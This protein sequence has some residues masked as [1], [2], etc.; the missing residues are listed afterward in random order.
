MDRP[1][2][3]MQRGATAVSM[4]LILLFLIS[5]LGLIEVSYLYWH[6]RDTQKVA[7]LAALAGAQQLNACATDNSNNT[8]AYGNA[9][10]ENKFTKGTL[11]IQCGTWDPLGNAAIA[12]HFAATTS[13]NTPNAVHVIAQQPV[14]SIW[15]FA[16]ALPNVTGEAVA[17]GMQPT[18]VFT[19]GSTL[20]TVSGKSALGQL[21][22]SVGLTIPEA[23]LV[24]YAGLANATVTPS[25]LLNALGVQVPANLS[26]GQFNQFLATTVQAHALIDVLNATVNAAGQ[27]Q[28]ASANATLV[29]AVNA[30][31]SAGAGQVTLGSTSATPG[32][33]AQLSNTSDVQSALNAQV[34]ALDLISGAVGVA[35]RNHAVQGA[36]TTGPTLPGLTVST[37]FSVIEPPSI[38]I[39]GVGT[40]ASTAQVRAFINVQLSS[41]NL[42]LIGTLLSGANTSINI[43][44]PIAIDLV[45]AQATVASL[46]TETSGAQH[47]T[48]NV[49]SSV[50]KVCV[51]GMTQANAFSTAGSCDQIP[52]S[53][54][55]GP[56]VGVVVGGVT[57]ASLG[58]PFVVT[59][60]PASGS[61]TLAAG[62][63]PTNV[64]SNGTPLDIGTTVTNAFTAVT[65][66]LLS[67]ATASSGTTGS[68][69]SN[70]LANDLWN[71]NAS[72]PYAYAKQLNG[73]L[74]QL[75]NNSTA[76]NTFL[77]TTTSQLGGVLGNTLSL[78]VGGLLTNVGGLLG[79]VGTALNGILS[80][81]LCTVTL[82]Q[83]A[84]ISAIQNAMP[85][86]GTTQ[87]NSL[88]A[89]LGFVLQTVQGP[90][91]QIGSG[92]VT[93][94]LQNALGVKLGVSTLT[95]RS[96]R[97]H[98]VQLVY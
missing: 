57:I 26:V 17:A 6:K 76:L 13:G 28:L 88:L 30:A 94:T 31:V 12:N 86:T 98:G 90:L 58:N 69:L 50:L 73:A 87:P 67:Q 9:T 93:P 48:F 3:A 72:A 10:V 29:S 78:N 43:N 83:G 63:P 89:A 40:T 91:N 60:L 65:A 46:C 81:T 5:M 45:Y 92:L 16:G 55:G 70:A 22:S 95:L 18:A 74:T 37:A 21:L 80:Q 85:G 97:C 84:C 33:F 66:G 59:G 51:G 39:G 62:D 82:I 23:S 47:A 77:T 42:P 35:T 7:D 11:S 15:G 20:A 75:S 61:A 8:A 53:T 71:N 79:G 68:T 64:P 34:N 41:G 4:L 54:S 96:L 56:M 52:T 19:I 1:S 25:G 38:G 49:N 32:L 36:I 2:R 27:Q 14:P 44:L 24:G